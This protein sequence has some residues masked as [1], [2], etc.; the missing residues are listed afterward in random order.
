MRR[1]ASVACSTDCR[2]F[3]VICMSAGCTVLARTHDSTPGALQLMVKARGSPGRLPRPCARAACL[4]TA[5]TCWPPAATAT[6]SALSTRGRSL[7]QRA[8]PR[9]APAAT[10][11]SDGREA[12]DSAGGMMFLFAAALAR[13]CLCEGKVLK[14]LCMRY[15][16]A[17]AHL[18]QSSAICM[19]LGVSCDTATQDMMRVTY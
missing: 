4:R 12:P 11:T 2:A 5:G 13:G 1:H 16:R 3:C 18:F 17:A 8:L 10:S 7:R 9:R 15:T 19:A 6:S 14:H